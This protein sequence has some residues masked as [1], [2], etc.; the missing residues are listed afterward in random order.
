MLKLAGFND[1]DARAERIVQLEHAI[2]EVH[3]SLADNEDIHKANNT[4][5][6]ADFAAKA[7]GLDWTA[8]FKAAGLEQA[9]QLYRVAAHRFR[10][11]SPHWWPR[12]RWIPGRTGWPIT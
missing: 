7:P 1:T 5:K 6:Q 12:P 8:Y 3:L 11:A 4:W 2:A 9:S 10:R